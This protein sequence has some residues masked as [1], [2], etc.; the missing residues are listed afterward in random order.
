MKANTTCFI[1]ESNAQTLSVNICCSSDQE[2]SITWKNQSIIKPDLSLILMG[3][4]VKYSRGALEIWQKCCNAQ[5]SH[6]TQQSD[7]SVIVYTV[8]FITSYNNETLFEL[9]KCLHEPP[10][11]YWHIYGW[12]SKL[13]WDKELFRRWFVSSSFDFIQCKEGIIEKI[14]RNLMHSYF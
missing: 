1:L 14:K 5:I 3:S 7:G 12:N 8:L 2:W 11:I 4:D 6:L 13:G 9:I 10:H